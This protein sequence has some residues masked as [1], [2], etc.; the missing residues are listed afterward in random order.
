MRS[1]VQVLHTRIKAAFIRRVPSNRN[2]VNSALVFQIFRFNT[3]HPYA[4]P[5]ISDNTIF[6]ILDEMSWLENIASTDQQYSENVFEIPSMPLTPT[7]SQMN[8]QSPCFPGNRDPP[9]SHG[10][11]WNN[12]SNPCNI[13]TSVNTLSDRGLSPF[14]SAN[15]Q[16]SNSNRNYRIYRYK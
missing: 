7:S 2:S 12:F 15:I 5:L 4:N 16:H 11:L 9:L 14:H 3:F 13:S 8:V 1:G 10:Y 6:L